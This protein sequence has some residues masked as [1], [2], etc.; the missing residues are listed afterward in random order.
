MLFRV[1]INSLLFSSILATSQSLPSE[2]SSD[3]QNNPIAPLPLVRSSLSTTIRE[4][5]KNRV[6]NFEPLKKKQ[7][8]SNKF[9]NAV[10]L[11]RHGE[12]D[13]DGS[14]GLNK[15]GKQRAQCFRKVGSSR[16]P[17]LCGSYSS[18]ITV[19]IKSK[20]VDLWKRIKVRYWINHRRKL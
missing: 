5:Q 15:D 10:L 16:L 4:I 18:M 1:I 11:V 17:F 12:K 7:K 9:D 14:I 19:L 13:K 3:N 6:S 8:K 20:K 2:L